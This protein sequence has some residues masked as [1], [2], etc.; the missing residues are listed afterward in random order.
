M[1]LEEAISK[2]RLMLTEVKS[3]VNTQTEIQLATAELVDG[4]IVKTEGEIEVGKT[5]LVETPE[6]DVPAPE[7]IHQT[8]DNLLISVDASGVIISIEPVVEE[9]EEKSEFSDKLLSEI[10]SMISP[11]TEQINS[12]KDQISTLKGEFHAFKEEPA[13][14]KITNNIVENTRQVESIYEAKMAK[15]LSMRNGKK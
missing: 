14:K 13:G 15:I 5:L 7:G 12:I 1:K 8:T 6:G 4:T 3:E 2:L 9:V 10:S 11:I